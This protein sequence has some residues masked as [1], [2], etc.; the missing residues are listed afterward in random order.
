MTVRETWKAD[1]E[2]TRGRMI[3]A[4]YSVSEMVGNFSIEALLMSSRT[5]TAREITS[6]D[7][8][9]LTNNCAGAH[10]LIMPAFLRIMWM[11]TLSPKAMKR[12]SSID[13]GI[14]NKYVSLSSFSEMKV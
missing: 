13:I 9:R 1:G 3:D 4:K 12:R 10:S 14:H 2:L 11:A 5:E 8:I 7:E 6:D